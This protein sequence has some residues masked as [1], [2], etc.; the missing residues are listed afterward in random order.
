MNQ[1][2]RK[3][4]AGTAQGKWWQRHRWGA[5]TVALGATVLALAT[6]TLPASAAPAAPAHHWQVDRVLMIG[7]HRMREVGPL[8]ISQ[9]ERAAARSSTGTASLIDIVVCDY[10]A[11]EHCLGIGFNAHEV[12]DTGWALLT[13]LCTVFVNCPEQFKIIFKKGGGGGGDTAMTAQSEGVAGNPGAGPFVNYCPA[14]NPTTSDGNDRVYWGSPGDCFGHSQT[15]WRIVP[16]KG[17]SF[18]MEN[19]TARG[20]NPPRNFRIEDISLREG[21]YVYVKPVGVGGYT[22]M[23]LYQLTS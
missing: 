10:N 4:H 13:I 14:A 6:T 23:G 22:K 9:A 15:S 3:H 11:N 17:N 5:Y 19:M 20:F 21:A 1:T 18:L 7:G 16:Q 2:G 12:A 8:S